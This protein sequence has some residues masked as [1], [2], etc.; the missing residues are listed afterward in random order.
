MVL[1]DLS[2]LQYHAVADSRLGFR[3]NLLTFCLWIRSRL[4]QLGVEH[5]V[6]GGIPKPAS[7][8]VMKHQDVA[9]VLGDYDNYM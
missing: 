6:H 4:L 8:H 7:R 2:A 9:I 3:E 1:L 5:S